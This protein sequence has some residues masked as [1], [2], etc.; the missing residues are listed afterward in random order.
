MS[1]TLSKAIRRPQEARSEAGLGMG[2][3]QPARALAGAVLCGLVQN[4]TNIWVLYRQGGS[5][6]VPGWQGQTICAA[7]R[8]RDTAHDNARV[9]GTPCPPPVASYEWGLPAIFPL[10]FYDNQPKGVFVWRMR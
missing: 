2:S 9:E 3:H 5:S 4:R 1:Q 7:M 10:F 6:R 8:W